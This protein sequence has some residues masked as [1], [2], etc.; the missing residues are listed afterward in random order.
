[1]VDTALLEFRLLFQDD[2]PEIA[3]PV[4]VQHDGFVFT[5]GN[6][7]EIPWR[8]LPVCTTRSHDSRGWRIRRYNRIASKL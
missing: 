8:S 6:Q 1:M 7:M 2:V 5:F 3:Q 4:D